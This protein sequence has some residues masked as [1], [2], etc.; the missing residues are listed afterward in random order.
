MAKTIS[1]KSS[2]K[3]SSDKPSGKPPPRDK[4]LG[5]DPEIRF[6]DIEDGDEIKEV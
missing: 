3:A 6:Y 4:I 1:K 2:V 5:L